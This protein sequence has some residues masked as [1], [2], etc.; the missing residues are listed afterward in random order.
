[1]KGKGPDIPKELE[2]EYKAAIQEL[3]KYAAEYQNFEDAD[4]KK[5]ARAMQL[6][7]TSHIEEAAKL[8]EV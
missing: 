7:A 3:G 1:M 2:A 8:L 4:L 5:S 6:V